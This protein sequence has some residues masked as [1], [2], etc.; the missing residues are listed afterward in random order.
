MQPIARQ[1]LEPPLQ[2]NS[3]PSNGPEDLLEI[4]LVGPLPPSNGFMYIL[5]AVDVFSRF[6]FAIPLRRP[7]VQSLLRG[8]ISI[9]T[10]HAYVPNT[11]LT[12]K[13]PTFTAEVVKRTMEQVGISIEHATIKH[14]QTISMIEQT[15]QKL[16]STLRTIIS[17]DQPQW[18]QY[19][20]NAVIAHNIT[21]HVSLKCAAT[22]L[23]HGRTP[24]SS[25]DLKYASPIHV[26]NQPTDT[27]K[28]LD[29]VEE[30]T[31]KVCAPS[32]Q[33]TINTRHCDRK[34]RGQALEPNEFV[35][36]LNPQNDGHSSKQ[37]LKSLHR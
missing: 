8:L 25:L 27:S 22:E 15:H 2:K 30:K 6:M 16:R 37:Q 11:I 18:D 28:M 31:S 12:D 23:L 5:T 1:H 3:D 7:D 21:Y 33:H 20:N 13:G 35:F 4:D 36:V 17:A 32:S 26:A 19:V 29:E 10:R 34:P 14:A 9:F 24:H